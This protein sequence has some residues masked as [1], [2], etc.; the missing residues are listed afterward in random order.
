MFRDLLS[1][2][3]GVAVALVLGIGSAVWATNRLPFVGVMEV[4]GWSANTTLGGNSPDPYSQAHYAR[5]GG[6]PL[7]AAEGLTFLRRADDDG[8]TLDA[9]CTYVIAGNTPVARRWTLEVLH[10]GLPEAPGED[11]LPR[12]L[13]SHG[14]IRAAD[15]SFTIRAAPVPQPGNWLFAGRSGSYT[16]ALSLYDTSV[17][18]DTGLVE[19]SMPSVRRRECG[20]G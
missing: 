4:D 6:L 9:N 14:I 10:G 20:N 19:L 18:S 8:D 2:L 1:M 13:H 15:G 17:A 5:S 16:L 12:A 3:L 7:A 11:G